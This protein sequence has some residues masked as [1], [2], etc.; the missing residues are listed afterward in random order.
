MDET[1]D[2]GKVRK[3]VL[4]YLSQKIAANNFVDLQRECVARDPSSTG[5]IPTAELF[6]CFERANMSLLPRE[7]EELQLELDPTKSGRVNYEQFLT[8]IFMT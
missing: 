6:N 3:V 8:A 5:S 7:F 1:L 4:L 2:K